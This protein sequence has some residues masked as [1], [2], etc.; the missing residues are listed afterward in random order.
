MTR[1]RLRVLAVLAAGAAALLASLLHAAPG[2]NQ[3]APQ[4]APPDR[5]TIVL[6]GD[7][8]FNTSGSTVD[9][10]GIHNGKQVTTDTLAGVAGAVDGNLAFIDLDTVITDRNDLGPEGIGK[11]TSHFRSHPAALKALIDSGFNVFSLANDHAYDYGA[12][13]IEETLYHLAV[14]NAKRPIAFAGIGSNFQEAIK[15]SYV[16]VG[17]ARVA[18]SAIGTIPEGRPQSRA[19]PNKAGQASYTDRPDFIAVVDKLAGMPA[20]YRI[21]SIHYGDEGSVAPDERQLADWRKFAAGEKNIDLIVG[22]HP[23]GAQAVALDGTSLIFY[24]LG[25]FLEPGTADPARLGIC[26]D[27]GLMAKVHLARVDK[28]WRVKAIEAIPLTKTQIRPERFA[29]YAGTER[30]H[31]LNH[32]ASSLD[33]GNNGKAVRFTPR[34]DGSGLYCAENAGPLGGEIGT[35]CQSW[36]PPGEPDEALAAKIASACEDKAVASKPAPARR[37]ARRRK[38]EPRPSG[39]FGSFGPR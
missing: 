19:G 36:Q 5:L 7:A 11:Q 1:G 37:K 34:P 39:P 27:Y 18:F 22:H 10:K 33:G 16:D 4:P 6:V 24:G 9:A 3:P 25:T 2:A 13:G 32:L 29:A 17:G 35:L 20:D 14:A 21:L 26:R 28:S 23:D 38:P 15:P 31:V 8:A 30:I 12:T